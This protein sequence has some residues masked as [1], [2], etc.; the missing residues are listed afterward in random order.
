MLKVNA[1][2]ERRRK[3]FGGCQSSEDG[4]LQEIGRQ[5]KK[6]AGMVTL[7]D[8]SEGGGG[9]LASL[10]KRREKREG[11]STCIIKTDSNG[12]RGRAAADLTVWGERI[13]ILDKRRELKASDEETWEDRRSK[14]GEKIGKRHSSYVK[15][16]AKERSAHF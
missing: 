16:L 1:F 5:K 8:N 13:N 15:T 2:Q 10:S 12:N 7:T 6:P 4:P 9:G 11:L 3:K 14:H